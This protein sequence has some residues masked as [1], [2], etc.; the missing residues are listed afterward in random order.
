MFDRAEK[1]YCLALQALKDK[2]YRTALTHLTTAEPRFRQDKDFR[3]LLETT[4]LLVAV[5]QKLSGR[6]GVEELNVTEVFSDG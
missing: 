3:L 1:A 6:D 4:R 5:K 2:D